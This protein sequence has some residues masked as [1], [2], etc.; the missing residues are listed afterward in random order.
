MVSH[1]CFSKNKLYDS[2][3]AYDY[4]ALCSHPT[5]TLLLLLLPLLV[6]SQFPLWYHRG[7]VSVH[8]ILKRN[9]MEAQMILEQKKM[10]IIL[11]FVYLCLNIIS[12]SA[13]VQGFL[14]C[15]M[16][17][18]VT[19]EVFYYIIMCFLIHKTTTVLCDFSC[20]GSAFHCVGILI[21]HQKK[22]LG[23]RHQ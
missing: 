22:P 13:R 11:C 18:F 8:T 12:V 6:R 2:S 9:S 1:N 23:K 14:C 19:S 10:R 5:K 21:K 20:Q 4:L 7:H 16:S 3:T 17:P 15:C